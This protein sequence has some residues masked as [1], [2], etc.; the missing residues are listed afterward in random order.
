[1]KK[2]VF[3]IVISLVLIVALL[4]AFAHFIINAPQGSNP[5]TSASSQETGTTSVPSTTVPIVTT[6]PVNTG[7]PQN[8][9][10]VPPETS[11]NNTES[12]P[13]D[14]ISQT[15]APTQNNIG[16]AEQEESPAWKKSYAN[17]ATVIQ[18]YHKYD[19]FALV[20][21]DDDEIPE[22]YMYGNGK[23]KICTVDGNSG[24]GIDLDGY[25]G[26]NY[27]E[28]SGN[29]MNITQVDNYLVMRI[30]RMENNAF[31]ETFCCMEDK[32]TD[33]PTYYIGDPSEYV[34]VSE[35]TMK[36]TVAQYIDTTNVKFL[37]ENALT[38]EDF[39]KLMTT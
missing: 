36:A 4:L 8:S 18:N 14:S 37:H 28:K 38:Y 5:N 11:P 29:F 21:L 27:C 13:Q 33:P 25:G 31:Y 12:Q 23:A 2:V 39:I 9:A 22:L 26:G 16:S 6:A 3:T 19:H 7:T 20:Y 10:P 24:Y 17:Y 30:Y 34:E 32:T 15:S 35:E 1:M